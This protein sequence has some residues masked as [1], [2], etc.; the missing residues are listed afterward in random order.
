MLSLLVTTLNYRVDII[1][2]NGRVPDA[3][4][5][6]YSIGILLAERIWLI[7]DAVKGVMVSNIAK[8]KDARETAYVI[9]ISNTGCFVIILAIIA[10]GKPFIDLMF[11]PEF[12][13]AYQVTLIVLAGVL[14]MIYYKL[15]AAYNIALGKQVVSFVFLSVAVVV[16]IILNLILIPIWGIYG[17]GISSVISYAICALLF[18][19]YFCRTTGIPLKDI[20]FINKGDFKKLKAK[21]R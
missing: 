3:S 4:I 19:I 6:V 9:R 5:G 10:L 15:I 8:G 20:L 11:G 17:A 13:G 18:I 14:S 16:H 1:M 7:P 21:L 12:E 2:L